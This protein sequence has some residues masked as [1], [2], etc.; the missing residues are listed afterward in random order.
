MLCCIL[1]HVYCGL[2][3]TVTQY[4]FAHSLPEVVPLRKT[5]VGQTAYKYQI[6]GI[7]TDMQKQRRNRGRKQTGKEQKEKEHNKN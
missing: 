6:M 1:L 3:F 5:R 7:R 2:S 4:L